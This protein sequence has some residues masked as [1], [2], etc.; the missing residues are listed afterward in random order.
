MNT[1]WI[2]IEEALLPGLGL[3][4]GRRVRACAAANREVA[5]GIAARN[6]DRQ[7]VRRAVAVQVTADYCA[8]V[9]IG[10]GDERALRDLLNIH[11]PEP[12]P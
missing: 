3:D 12:R 8:N 5:Q 6:L 1:N 9:L 7:Q 10:K 4:G 11:S 2:I